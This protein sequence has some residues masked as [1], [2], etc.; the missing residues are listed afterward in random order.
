MKEE[1][2]DNLAVKNGATRIFEHDKYGQKKWLKILSF[3]RKNKITGPE[4]VFDSNG[5]LIG[6]TYHI[7]GAYV[8]EAD[9]RQRARNDNSLAPPDIYKLEKWKKLPDVPNMSDP[10]RIP[11]S[12]NIA[13]KDIKI[14]AN[15]IKYIDVSGKENEFYYTEYYYYQNN[16][17]QKAGSR[18]WYFYGG[19]AVLLEEEIDYGYKGVHRYWNKG[20]KLTNIYFFA[21]NIL[22]GQN[23]VNKQVGLSFANGRTIYKNRKR[24]SCTR[25]EYIKDREKHP[26]LPSV[27]DLETLKTSRSG[28]Q[29]F[30]HAFPSA[31]SQNVVSTKIPSNT[32]I[33]R[34]I[35]SNNGSYSISFYENH[36]IVEEQT[37]KTFDKKNIPTYYSIRPTCNKELYRVTWDNNGKLKRLD[38]AGK[39]EKSWISIYYNGNGSIKRYNYYSRN[40]ESGIEMMKAIMKKCRMLP[41]EI[42]DVMAFDYKANMAPLLIPQTEK[43]PLFLA[44]FQYNTEGAKFANSRT[45]TT[46]PDYSNQAN[47]DKNVSNNNLQMEELNLL[48]DRIQT[49]IDQADKSFNKPYWENK[50][51]PRTSVQQT[52][53]KQ[54]SFNILLRAIPIAESAKY[55][56]NQAFFYHMLAMKFAGFSGRVFGNK[57]KQEFFSEA[58]KLINK[59]DNLLPQ[60]KASKDKTEL[61]ELYCTSA[62]VWREM[63][64]KALWGNHEYNKMYCDKKVM[65]L[66]ERALQTDP[67]NTKARKMLAQLRTPKKPIPQA[68]KQFEEIKP[69]KWND[70]Q[71]IMAQ[72]E[73]EKPIEKTN[74]NYLPIANLTSLEHTTGTVSVMRS[75]TS[76]W[77]EVTDNNFLI[78]VG[79]KIKTSPDAT[80]VSVTFQEDKTFLA[81]KP[82]SIVEFQDGQLYITRGDAYVRVIKRGSEFLVITPTAAVGVRGTQF[83]VNVKPDKTTETYLYKGIVEVRNKNDIGYLVPGEKIVS[84]KNEIKLKQET[85]NKQNRLQTKW[86]GLEAEQKRHNQILATVP[87]GNKRHPKNNG[88][89]FAGA[90][91]GTLNNTKRKTPSYTKPPAIVYISASPDNQYRPA[92]ALKESP[93][94]SLNLVGHCP[95]HISQNR[96]ITV[97][98][99]MNNQ[100]KAFSTGQY[101]AEPKVPYFN[102]VL[103]ASQAPLLPGLYRVEFIM[104]NQIVGKGSI[105]IKTPQKIALQ[106]AQ[107]VYIKA[108]QKMQAGLEYFFQGNIPAMK[109]QVQTALPDLRK[110]LYSAPKLPDI[111]A[112]YQTANALLSLEKV[113]QAMRSAQNS[114][115]KTWLD[116]SSVYTKSALINCQDKEFKTSLQKIQMVIDKLSND[117]FN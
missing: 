104:N 26:Y 34:V 103:S 53:P 22:E 23:I 46:P 62:G 78:W 42:K 36:R 61:S 91:S 1:I 6:L 11:N 85:F 115:V 92:L 114:K 111:Y 72:M 28:A 29:P 4:A 12:E 3:Y 15:A 80:D 10:P 108:L 57:G 51:A 60:L 13:Y 30:V 7:D 17:N 59:A 56:E 33:W 100:T 81:I 82:S 41:L 47:E 24:T 58:A 79:D 8:S 73:E 86:S 27:D 32:K 70:A 45:P 37:W 54:E 93:Y 39:M 64:R 77:K 67:G 98:W 5:K 99:Y 101:V 50:N 90:S 63:T 31:I 109:Q 44:L 107:Q 43:T 69:E 105:N 116:I 96:N 76:N 113:D 71:D 112:V 38:I 18:R 16:T 84:R 68:V 20:G 55:K 110:A 25:E 88:D 87:A 21:T 49:I 97:K 48:G 102:G 94:G 65:Q 75:G 95:L 14:P 106:T 19:K 40:T 52:N 2:M 66:Y 9:Y 89:P 83:E 35:L 117:S 74:E